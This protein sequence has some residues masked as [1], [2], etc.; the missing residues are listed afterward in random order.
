[1]MGKRERIQSEERRAE[2][3]EKRER[4]RERMQQDEKPAMGETRD[5]SG[6]NEM[7]AKMSP[8]AR[9][10][11]QHFMDVIKGRP[12]DVRLR[13]K[14]QQ[15]EIEV[16]CGP[17]TRYDT[18]TTGAITAIKNGGG[19]VKCQ[20][21]TADTL[22]KIL[23]MEKTIE[24]KVAN[25]EI[26]IHGQSARFAPII[27]RSDVICVTFC[28]GSIYSVTA[29]ALYKK[30]FHGGKLMLERKAREL[31]RQWMKEDRAIGNEERTRQF[32]ERESAETDIEEGESSQLESIGQQGD[33]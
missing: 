18:I 15:V 5:D 7:Y 11:M 22:P 12:E 25:I 26:E 31:L 24:F 17:K 8:K 30:G 28:G 21:A 27:I 1:M 4:E 2:G 32:T 6:S 20:K 33:E 23:T 3:I 9:T 16:I 10:Q 13:G 14:I 29:N 19:A